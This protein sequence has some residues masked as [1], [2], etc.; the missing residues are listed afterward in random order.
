MNE[1]PFRF[2]KTCQSGSLCGLGKA[3]LIRFCRF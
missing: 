3:A 2:W 1:E